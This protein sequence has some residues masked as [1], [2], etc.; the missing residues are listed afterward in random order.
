MNR[1]TLLALA[2]IAALLA[3][4]DAFAAADEAPPAAGATRERKPPL[5]PTDVQ[6]WFE[7]QRAFGAAEYGG[8]LFG[9]VLAAALRIAQ[10]DYDSWYEAYNGFADRIAKEAAE[11]LSRGHRVSAR[12]SFL[13]ATTYYQAS[14]FFLHGDPKDPRIARA[15]RLSTD[16]YKQSAKLHDPAI[17][18]VEIPYEKTTLPGYFHHAD[19]TSAPR[20]TLIMHTGFDGSAEEMHVSGAR[21]A[22]ERG[23]NV[24]A[25]DGPGQYGPLHREGLVFRPDWEKVVTPVVDFALKQPS[26]DPKR[27]ALMGISLGG[28]LAPRAAAFEKRLAALIANDGVYDFSAAFRSTVPSEKWE[29][30]VQALKAESAPQVDQLLEELA[31][32]SPTVRWSQ[33]HGM[34]SSGTASPRAFM[35]KALDY[36]LRDGVA[37]KIGCPTLVCEAED[38]LFFKGQPEALYDHLTCRKAL[39]RFTSDEGAGQHCQVGASRLAFARMF[40]WLDETLA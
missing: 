32:K 31:R 33:A 7:T 15:Y 4:G 17:E 16:C 14:E 3:T 27:I 9:E 1:R 2:P 25:F 18:P 6:F 35:A 30:F 36:N 19:K 28:V 12:D 20:P 10:G 22:V 40:D 29:P 21:A 8:A 5:F 26:V 23:Y 37:E 24:I 13:R 38:D 39:V 11:Q 34:W